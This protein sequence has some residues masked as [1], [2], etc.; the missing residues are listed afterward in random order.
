MGII[1]VTP[2]SFADGGQFLDPSAAEA[3]AVE[4]QALGADLIDVGGESTRPGAEAISEAEEIGRVQPVLRRLSRAVSIPISID[5]SKAEVAQV[6][7]DEGVSILNDVTGLSYDA[8]LAAIAARAGAGLILMHAR[9]RSRDMYKEAQYVSVAS[10]VAD[11]LRMSLERASAAGVRREA[12]VLDPGLGFAKKAEHSY[13]ALAAL[14]EIAAL[15]CPLLVGASRKS[16]LTAATGERPPR[17]RDMATA[18]A[19]TAA[20][21]FGAHIVRVH[22]V[23]AMID[24]VRVADAV[25]H[26]RPC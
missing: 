1:N 2:D 23:S 7:I 16:F 17:D 6:A 15:G 19:V 9:G 11:E 24:V 25:R 18:A 22:N 5:T 20:V 21:M 26:G 14:P 10:E 3:A 12:I 8:S 13:A 4:M